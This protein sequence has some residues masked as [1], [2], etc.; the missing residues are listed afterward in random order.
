MAV[1]VNLARVTMHG[2]LGGSEIA[3]WGFHLR[4]GTDAALTEPQRQQVAD[5]IRD[6]WLSA[7][8]AKHDLFSG[9]YTLE[10]VRLD[11]LDPAGGPHHLKTTDVT[12]SVLDTTGA[13]SFKG[14]GDSLPWECALVVSL[15]A[16]P[17][18]GFA[19]NKG[20]HRGR[21]YFPA[22]PKSSVA[23][24]D[25]ALPDSATAAY[26]TAAVNFLEL[27]NSPVGGGLDAQMRAVVLSRADDAAYDIEHL[28][29]DSKID[30]QRRRENR[31][32]GGY[33]AYAPLDA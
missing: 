16:Y 6:A 2:A 12:L 20:R 28:W 7:L 23:G 13:G 11:W 21:W 22:I 19:P 26:A 18:G 14:S 8:T 24:T 32:P 30:S 27:V 31:Q 9:A 33:R 29:V 15:A 1:P 10:H 4:V 3:L 25:A 5:R 17:Q